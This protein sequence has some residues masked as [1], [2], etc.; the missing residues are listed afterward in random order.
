MDIFKFIEV[1]FSL[2]P[3]EFMSDFEAGLRKALRQ[4][5]P[6]AVLNG[7][8]FHYRKC[9]RKKIIHFGVSKLWNKKGR[10]E[11]PQ[12]ASHAKKI[13]KM[14]SHLPLLPK[15]YFLAG[16]HQVKKMATKLKLSKNFEKF[17]QY[18]DR[19]WIA[20]VGIS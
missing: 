15:E 16:Y 7:C 3:K 2:N 13:Y 9:L 18:Y 14:I 10:S 1:E 6:E 5:Y 4:M 11:N 19:T 12:I 20:E 17:F 8:W